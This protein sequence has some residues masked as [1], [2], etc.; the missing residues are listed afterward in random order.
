MCGST[1]KT[2]EEAASVSPRQDHK[3]GLREPILS[4]ISFFKFDFGL[5]ASKT[6]S[7]YFCCLSHSTP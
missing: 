4:W 5:L 3:V 6:I 2:L 7:A 1:Q